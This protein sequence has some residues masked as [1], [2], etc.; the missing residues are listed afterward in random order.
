MDKKSLIRLVYVGKS[1]LG[2]DD[3]TYRTLLERHV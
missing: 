3:E 1:Q 2:L